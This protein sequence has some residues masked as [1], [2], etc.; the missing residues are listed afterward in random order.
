[1]DNDELRHWGIPNMKWGLRRFQNED[2]SL[3]PEGRERYRKN[4]SN[5]RTKVNA[6]QVLKKDN[7]EPRK[8]SY[9]E[10]KRRSEEYRI[11]SDYYRNLNN[12][13]N[14]KNK[15]DEYLHPPKKT[16][17]FLEKVGTEAANGF[18]RSINKY[19][20]FTMNLFMY[21]MMGGGNSTDPKAQQRA[22]WYV[23]W[24]VSSSKN[25][26]KDKD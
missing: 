12:A 19:V 22:K 5:G 17:W 25:K 24:V 13:I 2:G 10:M 23:E 1:M 21:E 8:M 14:E 7:D 16:N 18:A 11:E 9:D 6:K 3:T 20:E 4:K 26:N 15:Y